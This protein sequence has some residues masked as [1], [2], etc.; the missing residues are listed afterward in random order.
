[1]V[2]PLRRIVPWGLTG[3]LLAGALFL[4]LREPTDRRFMRFVVYRPSAAQYFLDRGAVRGADIEFTHDASKIVP[5][6]R[7]GDLGL[8]CP[9]GDREDPSG[10]RVFTDGR[11]FLSG[12]P[13]RP[14][15][16]DLMLGRAGDLPFCADFD[17]DG[18]ADSGVFRDGAWLVATQRTG[19]DPVIRFALGGAG[20]RPV[21]LNVKGA[22]NA[23]D[24]KNVVYGVYRHGSW[25]LDTRGSGAV[26]AT[27]TFGGSPQDVPLLIPRWSRTA[28]AMPAYSLA[29]FR[30]GVWHIKPDPDGKETLVFTFGAPGDL[31][32]FIR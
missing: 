25:Y 6:G 3:L 31:P 15:D 17:G 9:Q 19:I 4:H 21:V 32:G 18:I 30:D 1:M 28:D 10:F 8:A 12:R 29:I 26:N 14:V 5:F 2:L 16:G 20:D 23:A 22:G 11:W 7:P 27:H 24:R 13:D